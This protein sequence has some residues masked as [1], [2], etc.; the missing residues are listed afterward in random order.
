MK[1][2][3]RSLSMQF[4]SYLQPLIHKALEGYR[5]NSIGSFI[6]TVEFSLTQFSNCEEHKTLFLEALDFIVSHTV[7]ILAS[8]E[9]CMR[10]S[11]LV[12]DYF[13]L[14]TR[15]LRYNK[16]LFFSCGQLE[17]FVSILLNSVAMEGLDAAEVHCR[18]IK[19]LLKVL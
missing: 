3:M 2:G 17:S 12:N 8:K 4:S 18:F 9:N 11:D 13:G 6:Y 14:S 10:S 7:T 15:Y 5:I 19:E 1:H 16:Q